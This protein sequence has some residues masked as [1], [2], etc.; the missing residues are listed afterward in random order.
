[1][2]ATVQPGRSCGTGGLVRDTG[3]HTATHWVP[4]SRPSVPHFRPNAP[5]SLGHILLSI[6]NAEGQRTQ[7]MRT[8]ERDIVKMVLQEP[9]ATGIVPFL[10]GWGSLILATVALV[11]PWVLALVK[12][13]F[14]PGD[15]DI[16]PSTRIEV[17]YSALGPTIGLTGTLHVVHKDLFVESI[18]LAVTKL[19]D[20]SHHDF[21]WIVFR[22]GKFS[23][24]GASEVT[25]ELVSG[26]LLTR[27]QPYRYNVLFQDATTQQEMRRHI[28]DIRGEWTKTLLPAG[29][30]PAE[31]VFKGFMGKGGSVTDGYVAIDRLLYWEAGR[32]KLEIIVNTTRPDQSFVDAWVF[33][34]TA[35]DVK[36]L[37]LNPVIIVREACGLDVTYNFVYPAYQEPEPEP[38]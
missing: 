30:T 18:Q 35:D 21:D 29:A 33:D 2:A 32:Y 7:E 6:R 38:E 25:A 17:G 8:L 11:Q 27:A 22:A 1:M 10:K 13:L 26:F 19:K 23:S 9:Q 37:R 36:S 3:H 31:A 12:R 15:V 34:L 4:H 14:R 5:D 16:Y 24:T 28:D 20:G